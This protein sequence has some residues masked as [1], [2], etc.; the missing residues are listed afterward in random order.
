MKP[1]MKLQWRS[2]PP[3]SKEHITEHHVALF[4]LRSPLILRWRSSMFCKSP[5]YSIC[6]SFPQQKDTMQIP[7]LKLLLSPVS[8]FFL[9]ATSIL[10]AR[11]DNAPLPA[12][13]DMVISIFTYYYDN[14][15]SQYSMGSD[16][17][18]LPPE[19]YICWTAPPGTGSA[20]VYAANHGSE[21]EMCMYNLNGTFGW[22]AYTVNMYETSDCSGK[23]YNP[24]LGSSEDG[25]G[26]CVSGVSSC[27]QTC[28]SRKDWLIT[29]NAIGS[30]LRCGLVV[31]CSM[32][33]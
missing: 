33:G 24:E 8:T 14:C 5:L 15:L 16:W 28:V 10:R 1:W 11:A 20:H 3:D 6:Y 13:S 30:W 32:V 21:W 7:A 31:V 23:G 22:W 17:T 12:C 25:K 4:S 26:D 27:S 29:A 9:I 19:N 2:V 18:I